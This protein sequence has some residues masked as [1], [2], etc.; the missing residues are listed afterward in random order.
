MKTESEQLGEFFKNNSGYTRLLRGIKNKYIQL[1]EIKGNVIINNPSN[2][3]KQVLSGLMKKDY[4][5]NKSISINK[6]FFYK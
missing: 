5:R 4:S 3:E 1:G 6:T 2:I